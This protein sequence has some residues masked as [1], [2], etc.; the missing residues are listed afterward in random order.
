MPEVRGLT[1]SHSGVVHQP[2]ERYESLARR[3]F[4]TR[5]PPRA[6]RNPVTGSTWVFLREGQRT[7]ELDVGPAAWCDQRG[8]QVAAIRSW[9]RRSFSIAVTGEFDGLTLTS[10]SVLIPPRTRDE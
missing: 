2:E 8:L 7:P 10:L 4:A 5:S 6:R 3:A 9:K 1:G